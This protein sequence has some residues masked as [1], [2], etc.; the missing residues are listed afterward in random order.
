MKSARSS[1]SLRVLLRGA[2]AITLATLL[3]IFGAVSAEAG[4]PAVVQLMVGSQTTN[5]SGNL[6]AVLTAHLQEL[7]VRVVVRDPDAPE[8]PTGR[9]A[10]ETPLALIW[11][12]SIDDQVILQFYE[13]K[14]A[15]LRV[16]QVPLK[17]ADPASIEEVALIV[18]SFVEAVLLTAT[19]ASTA[20]AK[21]TGGSPPSPVLEQAVAHDPA[22]SSWFRVE[23]GYATT[24]FSSTTP[25][26]H[27]L[28]GSFGLQGLGNLKRISFNLGLA[29]T[30]FPALVVAEE[31]VELRVSRHPIEL[32]SSAHFQ[33]NSWWALEPRL[34]LEVDI[35]H[36]ETID[37]EL[38]SAS[39]EL[40][41]T[42]VAASLQI[43]SD[44]KI[45]RTGG[46]YVQAG[47]DVM[48]RRF[49][50]V[51]AA[52]EGQATPEGQEVVLSPSPVRPRF[53]V[54]IWLSFP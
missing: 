46:V 21:A 18:R 11:I 52:P 37:S 9:E 40:S 53:G 20:E 15:H 49:D 28:R 6:V 2:L 22:D 12:R 1:S 30:I 32:H 33:I 43:G 3:L 44:A 39:A 16:R 36:R 17:G 34:G 26:Q 4:S 54:G 38:V 31:D 35:L 47:A 24:D 27:G 7:G 48:L 50:Y 23:L 29:Y 45:W 10:E 19:Q 41:R 25:W 8:A 51:I 42:T 5:E 13:P 14:G